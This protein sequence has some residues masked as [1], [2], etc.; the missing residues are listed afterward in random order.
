MKLIE[1]NLVD[2]AEKP[3]S[4][5]KLEK[6]VF[7]VML[8]ESRAQIWEEEVV[9]DLKLIAESSGAIAGSSGK[10]FF[11]NDMVKAA[12]GMKNYFTGE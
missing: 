10:G 6:F 8:S 1:E 3:L 5:S 7:V 2:T 4:F 9:T 12:M 11:T